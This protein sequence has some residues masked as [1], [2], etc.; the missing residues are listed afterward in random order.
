MVPVTRRTGSALIELLVAMP[1]ALL[2]AALAVQLFVVQ[3][4]ITHE[5]SARISNHAMLEHATAM[6]AADVQGAAATD[7]E[8]W[9]DTSLIVRAPLLHATVCGTPA[10]RVVDVLDADPTHPLR[11]ITFGTVQA[12]DVAALTLGDT[13][14]AG[15]SVLARDTLERRFVITD[16]SSSGAACATSP[17]RLHGGGTPLRI[18][19]ATA[20]QEPPELG[21]PLTVARRTEWRSYRASDGAFYLGRHDWNGTAWT[22]IQPALGPLLPNAQHGFRVRVLHQDG[23][24]LSSMSSNARFLELHVR[25]PRTGVAATGPQFDSLTARLAFRGGR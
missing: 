5:S 20:P 10:P 9:T 14:L 3:L 8:S 6:I 17:L 13:S 1:L 25:T 23:T 22:T 16:V 11:S 7:V 4:R 15:M 2:L 19:L 18:T 21:S 24:P 12:G